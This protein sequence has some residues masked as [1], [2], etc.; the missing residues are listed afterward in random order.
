M[1][2]RFPGSAHG[3]SREPAGSR[4]MAA[5]VYLHEIFY[6]SFYLTKGFPP[7]P[8]PLTLGD[9]RRRTTLT[10]QNLLAGEVHVDGRAASRFLWACAVRGMDRQRAAQSPAGEQLTSSFLYFFLFKFNFIQQFGCV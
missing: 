1:W 3:K 8:I 7:S 9:M 5:T 2:V 10:L 6:P 4:E